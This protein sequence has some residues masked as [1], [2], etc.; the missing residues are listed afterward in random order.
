MDREDAAEMLW[1]CAADQIHSSQKSSRGLSAPNLTIWLQFGDGPNTVS[2]STVSNTELSEIFGP[3]RVPGRELSELARAYYLCAKSFT[4]K[5]LQRKCFGAICLVIIA[6]ESLCKTNFLACF[7]AK[8]DML[9]PAT[10]QRK[11]SGRTI[12]VILTK[13]ITKENVSRNSF[14]V[15]SARMV[16][17]VCQSELTEFFAELTELALELSEV[18]IL[19][20]YSRN[21]VPPVS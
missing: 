13:I 1:P 11:S 9:V 19:K 14:V 18:S 6:E 8:R 21:S 20:Q 12:C 7:L 17:F 10:L 15:L 5:T 4:K 3:H 2:E 16:L